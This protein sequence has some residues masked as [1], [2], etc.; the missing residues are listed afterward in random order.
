M[1]KNG[2]LVEEDFNELAGGRNTDD[3]KR[4]RLSFHSPSKKKSMIRTPWTSVEKAAVYHGVLKH[5]EGVWKAIKD[6]ADFASALENR[7]AV[8]IKVGAPA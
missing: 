5:G 4:K 3:S 1:L 2:E 8:Q 7:T 6:D